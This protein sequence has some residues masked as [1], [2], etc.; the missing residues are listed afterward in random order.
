MV[1]RAPHVVKCIAFRMGELEPQLPVGTDL[2]LV[3][4]PKVD[5]WEGRERVD[6]V[7]VDVAKCS[8]E[9]FVEG[10]SSKVNR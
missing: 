9:A 3:V 4:E 6:L 1:A 5:C 7:V 10:R 8:E 2:N